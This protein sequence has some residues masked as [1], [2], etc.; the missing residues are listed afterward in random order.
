MAFRT[1]GNLL[2]ETLTPEALRALH[3]REEPHSIAVVLIKPEETPEFVFFPHTGAVVSIVSSTED[4]WMV[5]SGVIGSEGMFYL[6]TAITTPAPAGSQAVVQIDGVFSRVDAGLVRGHFRDHPAFRDGLLAFT[7]LFIGQITQN[8]V[9]NRLH[10]IEQ[11]LAKWLLIVRDRIGTDELHLTHD[12][13]AN[14]LGIH[15]PGV[16]IAV[17]ALELDG[18]IEHARNRITITDHAGLLL[19]S[20]E[21]Y[22]VVH[23]S[24]TTYRSAFADLESRSA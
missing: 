4:G 14:M 24:L 9:C 17:T 22:G 11:R 13:L 3:P 10:P 23:A 16:S 18:V 7:S 15:R 5:E 2:L 19:R 20:C 21:C 1:S 6:Q 8:L 12:F